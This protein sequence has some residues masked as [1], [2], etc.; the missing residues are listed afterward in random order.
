MTLD[1]CF[2]TANNT[3][4]LERGGSNRKMPVEG[5]DLFNWHML[6]LLKLNGGT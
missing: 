2:K 5:S 4:A 1:A 3:W 6:N